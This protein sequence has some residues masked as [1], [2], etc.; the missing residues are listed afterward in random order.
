MRTF[1]R[2]LRIE[3]IGNRLPF[4]NSTDECIVGYVYDVSK[5]HVVLYDNVPLPLIFP[6]DTICTHVYVFV[7]I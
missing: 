6:I 4:E 3:N 1:V 5:N 7:L 2:W